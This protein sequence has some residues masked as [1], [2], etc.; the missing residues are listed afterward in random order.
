LAGQL[1]EVEN[2]NKEFIEWQKQSTELKK[3]IDQ[4]HK[5]LS[6]AAYD[7]FQLEELEQAGFKE[8]EIEEIDAELKLLANAEG[9]QLALNNAIQQLQDGE[10]PILAGIKSILTDLRKY[11][12]VQ[13]ALAA[14]ETRLQSAYVEMQDIVREIDH[15]SS[16]VQYDP[17]KMDKLNDR[18]SLGYRLQKKHNVNSTQELLVI[19]QELAEKMNQSENLEEII[20][21]KTKLN[22]QLKV[23]LDKKASKLS[24][25]RQKQIKPLED[26]VNKLLERVGMPSAKLKVSVSE[27]TMNASGVDQIDFLFDANKSGQFQPLKKVASGG[28]LSRVMLCIK[29]LVA[30]SVDLPTMIFDEI[31]TGISGEA[32]RQVGIIMQELS[33]KRQIIC[34]TH[35]PQIAAKASTQYQVYKQEQKPGAKNATGLAIRTGIR[36]LNKDERIDVI[37]KMLSGEKPTP[38]ALANAREMLS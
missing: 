13:S 3:L 8:N 1:V 25:S 38:A 37:A 33:A 16:R 2:F 36:K 22:Q 24:A 19:Q 4:Q 11:V 14:V 30:A 35:Q 20:K 21:E 6:E 5:I 17:A 34:I 15:I 29:S 32:A 9:I 28:E 27:T 31:D 23:A 18:L 10:S 7:K 26:Q 12:S